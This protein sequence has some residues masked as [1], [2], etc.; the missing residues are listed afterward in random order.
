MVT[1]LPQSKEK[2]KKP[3]DLSKPCELQDFVRKHF[4]LVN[5]EALYTDHSFLFLALVVRVFFFL[6]ITSMLFMPSHFTGGTYLE[7]LAFT[8]PEFAVI[9]F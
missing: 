7:T 6:Y 4:S 1:S 3:I 8:F 5:Y 2:D 9:I